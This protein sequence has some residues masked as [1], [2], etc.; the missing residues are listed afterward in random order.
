MRIYTKLEYK[1]DGTQYVLDNADSFEY[2]GPIERLCGASSQQNQ[3]EAQ[4]SAAYTQA[5]A[6]SAAVFGVASAVSQQLQNT[7]APTVA[8]GPNQQGFSAQENSNLN[9]EAITQTG[10]SYKNASEALKSQENSQ[11]GGNM[12]LPS[13][14]SVGTD[15]SL[16]SSAANQTAS[17]LSG[18]TQQNYATGRANYDTAVQGLAGA[19]NPLSVASGAT[20]AATGSGQAAASTANQI[21]SQ[22]N[23]WMQLV[24]GALGA[25]GGAASGGLFSSAS[26]TGET[27]SPGNWA[28]AV[29]SGAQ[30]ASQMSTG[31][32]NLYQIPEVS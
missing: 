21:A 26:G 28:E 1:W 10:Q 15:A 11:G 12:P 32:E 6:Q 2:N 7:F 30:N 18:I 3:I 9:S 27:T 24:S 20:N 8:A 22:N 25:V 29:T 14:A 31:D 4:Q 5:A 17:E 13:G 23:S 16:A 19:A